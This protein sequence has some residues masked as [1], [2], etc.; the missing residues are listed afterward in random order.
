MKRIRPDSCDN[1]TL[2][3]EEARIVGSTASLEDEAASK[4]HKPVPYSR[5]GVG[6]QIYI[7]VEKRTTGSVRRVVCRGEVQSSR[8]VSTLDGRLLQ[9]SLSLIYRAGSIDVREAETVVK[10]P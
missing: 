4:E 1:F 9:G 10:V 6:E 2:V 7:R 3:A 5:A 8:S